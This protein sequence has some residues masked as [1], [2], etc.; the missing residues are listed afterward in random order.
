MRGFYAAT[1]DT[2]SEIEI[3]ILQ[4]TGD[5][6]NYLII[7]IILNL[8]TDHVCALGRNKLEYFAS[9]FRILLQR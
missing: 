6:S 4:E 3:G 1:G 8:F 9:Q 7:V 5:L 2:A